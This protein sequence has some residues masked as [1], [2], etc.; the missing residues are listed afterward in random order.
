MP[1]GLRAARNISM[2]AFSCALKPV[3]DRVFTL[4]EIV[5]AHQYMESNHQKGKIVVT[6][7]ALK[8]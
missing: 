1:K 4:E 5:D 3:F 7:G 6:T 8:N 2:K